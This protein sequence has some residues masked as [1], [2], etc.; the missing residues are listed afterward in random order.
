MDSVVATGEWLYDGSIPTLVRVVRLD[1]D[2]WY[3]LGEA[4]GDL[5]EGERPALNGDG[6]VFYVR[7]RPGWSPGRP[8]WPDSRGFATME[9]AKAAAEAAVPAPIKWR[10]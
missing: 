10:R 2:F 7:L 3:A 4:D 9:E 5:E 8:F 6:F 1:Y